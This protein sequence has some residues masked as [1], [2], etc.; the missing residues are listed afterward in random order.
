MDKKKLL[1]Y[2]LYGTGS[3]LGALSLKKALDAQKKYEVLDRNQAKDYIASNIVDAPKEILKMD[4]SRF[5]RPTKYVYN[6]ETINR[7][8][9]EAKIKGFSRKMFLLQSKKAIEGRNAMAVPL[10]QAD[11]DLIVGPEKINK[12]VLLHEVGHL[13]PGADHR[14]MYFTQ[15]RIKEE[16]DA[17]NEAYKYT[18]PA[19][20]DKQ[21]LNS[22]YLGREGE[23]ALGALLGAIAAVGFGISVRNL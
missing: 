13:R 3:L 16:E 23:K 2:S 4:P 10:E 15:N 11:F 20:E 1:E 14:K 9:D 19:P 21:A 7:A 18:S 8:L 6:E 5:N 17:W 12:N 22:Y